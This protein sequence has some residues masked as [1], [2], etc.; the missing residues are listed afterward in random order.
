MFWIASTIALTAPLASIQEQFLFH[1]FLKYQQLSAAYGDLVLCGNR[2]LMIYIFDNVWLLAIW[3]LM[4]YFNPLIIVCLTFLLTVEANSTVTPLIAVG[5]FGMLS[6][7]LTAVDIS[8]LLLS[9][10]TLFWLLTVLPWLRQEIY[11]LPR[12]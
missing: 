5:M 1:L 10:A 2:K 9:S 12:H 11:I 8:V 4:Q 3:A 6:P 7:S